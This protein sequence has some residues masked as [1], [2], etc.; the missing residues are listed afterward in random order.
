MEWHVFPMIINF[1]GY[2]KC[3]LNTCFVIF[4]YVCVYII[5]VFFDGIGFS[6][7]YFV[8]VLF[9]GV[10]DFVCVGVVVC[11]CDVFISCAENL[12]IQ[13]SVLSTKLSMIL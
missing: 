7:C 12:A 13:K 10:G 4:V 3:I 2:S 8:F 6:V 1:K 11:E 9:G 5:D